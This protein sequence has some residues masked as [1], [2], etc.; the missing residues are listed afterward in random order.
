VI[1]TDVNG[2]DKSITVDATGK[3][4]IQKQVQFPQTTPAVAL[5]TITDLIANLIT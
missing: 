1:P 4:S 5:S 3:T 2:T